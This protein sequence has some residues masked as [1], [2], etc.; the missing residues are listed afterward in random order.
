MKGAILCLVCLL[1]LAGEATEES[2]SPTPPTEGDIYLAGGSSPG[3]G[4][5]M[6]KYDGRWGS[7]CDDGWDLNAATVACRSLG[8]TGALGHT[9]NSYFGRPHKGKESVCPQSTSTTPSYILSVF[10]RLYT[11]YCNL[12]RPF[13]S[14]PISYSLA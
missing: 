13:E 12:S 8:F 9:T 6:V 14:R 11:I 10:N 3:T 4:N 1:V 5:V 7:V 2:P